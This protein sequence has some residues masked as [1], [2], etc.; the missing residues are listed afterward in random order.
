MDNQI[1]TKWIS[2]FLLWGS[3]LFCYIIFELIT[4]SLLQIH[5]EFIIWNLLFYYTIYLLLFAIT[6][7]MRISYLSLN[8]IFTVWAITEYFVVEFRAR[9]IMLSDIMAWRTAS[10][11]AGSYSYV[12]TVRMVAAVLLMVLLSIMVWKFPGRAPRGKKRIAVLSSVFAWTVCWTICFFTIVVPARSIDVS[13]WNPV[14]TYQSQGYLLCTMR[15]AGYLH[16]KKPEGYNSTAVKQLYE[17]LEETGSGEGVKPVNIICIM[18]ESWADLSVIA[19]LKTDEPYF[20]YYNSMDENCI[21]GSVY[22]PVFGSMTSNTEYEFLTANS[23]AF[24]PEGSVPFQIYMKKHTSSI[25]DSVKSQGYQTIA[26]HPY[27]AENWNRTEAYD[28]L[29]FDQFLAQDYFADSPTFR[30]YVSDRGSYEK[31]IQLTEENEEPLFIFLVTMQNHGGYNLGFEAS[32]HLTEYEDMPQ[33]EQYLTLIKESDNALEY[34]IEYYKQSDEPTLIM[35][36]GDHQPAIERELYEA[37]LGSNI[38]SWD[39]EQ[40]LQRYITPFFIWTNYENNLEKQTDF[41]VL[42]L[43]NQVLKAANLPLDGYQT[44]LETLMI[45]VPMIHFL[46]YFDEEGDWQSWSGWREKESYEWLQ[47]FDWF[48]YYRMFDMK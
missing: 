31:V 21:K 30:G 15:M 46:G 24:A 19:Q 4:G 26:M 27:P 41:S 12:L 18:N 42:Y 39:P 16:V 28:S 5:G 2:R 6:N 34:L 32:V 13:M 43:S 48:Q 33:A 3:P 23:M 11:V 25:V 44:F 7:S 14:E 29:G 22:V 35:M 8:L 45:R 1:H 17:D 36:F 9:P 38:S 20:S 37:L 47:P 10:T 40:H